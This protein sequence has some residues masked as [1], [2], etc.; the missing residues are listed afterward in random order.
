[1][2]KPKSWSIVR[3]TNG[4]V[5]L[6]GG[7]R[8]PIKKPNATNPLGNIQSAT[9]PSDRDLEKFKKKA[10]KSDIV[11]VSTNPQLYVFFI[12]ILISV[13][14]NVIYHARA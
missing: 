10:E 1:M 13:F 2:T 7:D 14:C 5:H 12:S 6:I 11:H 4:S 3:E 8:E 9:I